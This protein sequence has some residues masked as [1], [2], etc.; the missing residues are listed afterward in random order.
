MIELPDDA[1][2]WHQTA[3][4]HCEQAKNHSAGKEAA[5]CRLL[6]MMNGASVGK[7]SNLGEYYFDKRGVFRFR[8]KNGD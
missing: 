4:M 5:R 2:N 6:D 1:D 7:I 8:K 3:T